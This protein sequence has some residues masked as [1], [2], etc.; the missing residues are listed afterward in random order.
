MRRPK[1]PKYNRKYRRK[2]LFDWISHTVHLFKISTVHTA[3]SSQYFW[4]D[5]WTK[6]KYKRKKVLQW[7]REKVLQTNKKKVLQAK[8]W[9]TPRLFQCLMINAIFW[10][11]RNNSAI[12]R[13]AYCEINFRTGDFLK[14]LIS[15]LLQRNNK[16]CDSHLWI[17]RENVKGGGKSY[18]IRQNSYCYVPVRFKRSPAILFLA[19]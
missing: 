1:F 11:L 6:C 4:S 5:L 18:L 12:C 13:I 8:K 3:K 2:C 14:L 9:K 16:I 15:W 7:N 17:P 10:P 19:E